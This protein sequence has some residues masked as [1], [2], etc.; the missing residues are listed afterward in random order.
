MYTKL[1]SPLTPQKKTFSPFSRLFLYFTFYS[2]HSLRRAGG[3]IWRGWR[4]HSMCREAPIACESGSH[5]KMMDIFVLGSWLICPRCCCPGCFFFFWLR[6][7]RFSQEP[8]HKATSI[9]AILIATKVGSL[10]QSDVFAHRRRFFS[11]FSAESAEPASPKRAPV[12]KLNIVQ[13]KWK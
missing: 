7:M 6:R 12:D 10:C 13:I 9:S 8:N 5:T 1:G 11:S 3:Q 4:F 2:H